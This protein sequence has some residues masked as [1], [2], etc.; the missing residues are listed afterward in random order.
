ML[1][2]NV[3]EKDDGGVERDVLPAVHKLQLVSVTLV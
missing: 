3:F 2:M 1:M